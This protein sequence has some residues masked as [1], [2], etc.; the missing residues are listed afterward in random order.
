MDLIAEGAEAQ[1]WRVDEGVLKKIRFPKGYRLRELDLKLRKFRNRREFKVLGRLFEK[2]VRVPRPIEIFEGNIDE[3][4]FTFENISGEVLKS[5]MNYDLLC[6]AFDEIVKMHSLG[7]VH[8][9]LTSL[10]MIVRN[11]EVFL[12][13]FGLAEFSDKVEERAVDLN[14]F[15]VCLKIEH[16]DLYGYKEELIERYGKLDFGEKVVER[17]AVIEK[18]G[19]NK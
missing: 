4:F 1:I 11:D 9:D 16:P 6:L 19:R 5:V 8:G 18:R 2:G 14:L 17:L 12:V 10:N 3:L 13:D 7:I 15:F